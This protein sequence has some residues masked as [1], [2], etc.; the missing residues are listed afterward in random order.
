MASTKA[1]SATTLTSA[2]SGRR[3]ADTSAVPTIAPEAKIGASRAKVGQGS[4]LPFCIMAAPCLSM[5]RWTM[6][7]AVGVTISLM[8]AS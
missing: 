6:G 1:P 7:T 3:L 2:S 5:S 8:A 4:G